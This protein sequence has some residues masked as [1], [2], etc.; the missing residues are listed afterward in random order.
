MF[1]GFHHLHIRKR[2]H[3]K[4][5]P[6]PHP[7]KFKRGVDKLIYVAAIGGPAMAIP[8]IL[9]IWVEKNASGVSMLTWSML[10]IFSLFWITYG[11]IHKDWPILFTNIGW[12]F[13]D[14]LIIIGLFAYG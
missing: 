8:Q 10:L 11:I 7:N 13:F 2:I 12:L 5:E 14:S 9:K 6:Y 4:H 3:L 1:K